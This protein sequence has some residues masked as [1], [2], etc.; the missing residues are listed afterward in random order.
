MSASFINFVNIFLNEIILLQL[1]SSVV[2]ADAMSFKFFSCVDN[3]NGLLVSGFA[4]YL[5][6]FNDDSK[7]IE[8]S[9][10]HICLNKC[11]QDFKPNL[12]LMVL[13]T[14]NINIRPCKDLST[15]KNLNR[16]S[17][18]IPNIIYYL[19]L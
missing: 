4:Y 1:K 15:P 7:P 17:S 8:F 18:V 2:I 12:L 9:N 10:T 11:I 14:E 13:N 3:F 5:V 16:V 19:P 6:Q